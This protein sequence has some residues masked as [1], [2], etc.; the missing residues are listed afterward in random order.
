M[1]RHA[2]EPPVGEG[3]LPHC[4][5]SDGV[6]RSRGAGD[7]L[8][9]DRRR[10][11]AIR[12]GPVCGSCCG[13]H[14]RAGRRRGWVPCRRRGTHRRNA[15]GP[16]DD[17][18]AD[19]STAPGRSDRGTAL[20]GGPVPVVTAVGQRRLPKSERRSRRSG[21]KSE[22]RALLLLRVC[23]A[24]REVS[25][26]I[27]SVASADSR[28]GTAGPPSTAR[29]RSRR[30]LVAPLPHVMAGTRGLLR[31]VI[32]SMSLPTRTRAP[33]PGR[34]TLSSRGHTR[35]SRPQDCTPV[36]GG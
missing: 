30:E 31:I 12:V 23:A 32:C 3:V 34:L 4:S 15:A 35:V 14:C 13:A 25:S 20:S 11:A 36:Y 22:T 1:R 24:S 16:G 19:S 7:V 26:S 5:P 17:G 10:E 21:A 27:S 9:R 6:R 2:G 29:W 28:C 8:A 18:W 33:G